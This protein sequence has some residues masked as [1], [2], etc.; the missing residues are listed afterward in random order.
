[1]NIMFGGNEVRSRLSRFK[2]VI[3]LLAFGLVVGLLASATAHAQTAV[4]QIN[5]G[6][7]AVARSSLTSLT[8]EARQQLRSPT[9]S[10]E[11]Q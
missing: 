1:M 10:T 5:Y 3:V 7:G 9:P 8:L 6:G 2:H 4:Y 11:W